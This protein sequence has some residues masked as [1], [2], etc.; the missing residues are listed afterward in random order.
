[1]VAP[2]NDARVRCHEPDLDVG[3]GWGIGPAMPPGLAGGIGR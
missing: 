1:V 2:G 3:L